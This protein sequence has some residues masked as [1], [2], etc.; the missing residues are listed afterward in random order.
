MKWSDIPRNP[1]NR[2]LRQFAAVWLVFFLFWAAWQGFYRGRAEWGLALVALALMAGGAGLVRP[3]LVRWIFV[4][5]MILAFPIG[6]LISQMV[7]MILFYGMFTPM[8][9]LLRLRGRDR[10]RLKPSPGRASF[11]LRKETPADLRRYL[12]QY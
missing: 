1:T 10:L 3:P 8:A 12:R 6:W 11:W 9:L 4:G 7:L 5:W 2:V